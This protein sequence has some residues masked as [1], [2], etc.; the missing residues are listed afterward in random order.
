MRFLC[1][2]DFNKDAFLRAPVTEAVQEHLTIMVSPS[3]TVATLLERMVT[4]RPSPLCAIPLSQTSTQYHPYRVGVATEQLIEQVVS[5]SDLVA[6]IHAHRQQLL[7]TL[8][9]KNLY[10][11][12]D[13]GSDNKFSVPESTPIR[14]ACQ[15]FA[16]KHVNGLAVVDAKKAMK[17][18]LTPDSFRSLSSTH[19]PNFDAP[20]ATAE[21]HGRDPGWIAAETTLGQL[22]QL[23]VEHRLHRVWVIGDDEVPKVRA[24]G[25]GVGALLT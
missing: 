22:L 11:L 17:A 19:W 18:C 10:A 8:L 12:A 16:K 5:Q 9:E 3:T 25:T 6:W 7:P 24:R 4:V 23:L 2:K 1:A 20:I 13:L 15:L 14:E 21:H